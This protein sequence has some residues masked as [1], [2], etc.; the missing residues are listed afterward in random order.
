[1]RSIAIITVIMSL[2][3]SSCSS[4]QLEAKLWSEE[5]WTPV[6][7]QS[8]KPLTSDGVAYLFELELKRPDGKSVIADADPQYVNIELLKV[9]ESLDV[10]I[11]Q[12]HGY[13]ADRYRIRLAKKPSNTH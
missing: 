4:S 7:V 2:A 13:A 8:V 6:V 5:K 3:L 12:P 11:T 1:M 10:V 9:G